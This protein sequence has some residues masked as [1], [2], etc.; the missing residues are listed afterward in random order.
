MNHRAQSAIRPSG[1][2]TIEEHVY[3]LVTSS[4]ERRGQRRAT[5][6][7]DGD[8]H[9]LKDGDGKQRGQAST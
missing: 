7:N 3:T 8:R 5:T 2:L 9:R 6:K 4:Q 1:L